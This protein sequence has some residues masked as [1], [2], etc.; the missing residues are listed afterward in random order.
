MRE[1]IHV[2]MNKCGIILLNQNAHRL[3]GQ[4]RAVNLYFNRKRDMIGVERAHERLELVF[5]V[6][7]K[8]NYWMI[9]ANPFCRHFGIRL[10]ATQKFVSPE[11][12]EQGLL[13]LD[14]SSTVKVGGW[15]RRKKVKA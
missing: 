14:L 4:P 1:R 11:I 15:T 10:D 8:D 13:M 9:H 7:Q 6:K 12:S 3:L 5:P 2:T